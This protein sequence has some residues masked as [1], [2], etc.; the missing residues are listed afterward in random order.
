MNHRNAKLARL[1]RRFD[2]SE[3][4]VDEDIAGIVGVQAG[5]NPHQRG[6]SGAVFSYESVYLPDIQFEVHSTNSKGSHETLEY[7]GHAN[8]R[9]GRGDSACTRSPLKLI[10]QRGLYSL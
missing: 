5:E 7:L 10:I 2:S 1:S 3:H 6:L 9:L 8:E 4:A